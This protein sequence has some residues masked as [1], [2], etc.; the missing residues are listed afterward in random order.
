MSSGRVNLRGEALRSCRAGYYGLINHIDDQIRR[1][2][3]HLN[4]LPGSELENTLIFFV[5][6][7]GEML[8]DHYRFGKRMPY[9]ASARV[10]FIVRLPTAM[11]GVLRNAT[12]D[13][14][15]CL[16]DVMPTCLEAAGL[17]IPEWVDG[18]SLMPFL[19]GEK[20]GSWREFLHIEN[21]GGQESFHALTDGKEKFIWFSASGR[22]QFFNIEEDPDECFDRIITDA[23]RASI[24]R[25]RMIDQLKSRPEGFVCKGRLT[26]G[27]PHG[28]M[29]PTG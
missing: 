17:D 9:E 24:W 11:K 10:P 23:K 2:V 14:P 25:E 5:S 6:D 20:E 27:R 13:A 7:H 29:V 15:V 26:A 8:G 16:E 22:E 12:S 4:G 21:G 19:R 18:R 28:K 3:Y 1:L